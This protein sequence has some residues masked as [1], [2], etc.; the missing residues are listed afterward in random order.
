MFFAIDASPNPESMGTIQGLL[1]TVGVVI[2]GLA[3]AIATSLFAFSHENDI[4]GGNFVYPVL[5][6][7]CLAGVYVSMLLPRISA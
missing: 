1:Q 6:L 7:L 3:P 5:A 2:R 4:L